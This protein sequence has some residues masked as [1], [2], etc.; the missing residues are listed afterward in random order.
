MLYFTID[1]CLERMQKKKIGE[2]LALSQNTVST[3]EVVKQFFI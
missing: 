1:F 2:N 3:P